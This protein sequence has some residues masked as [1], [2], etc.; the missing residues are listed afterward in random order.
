MAFSPSHGLTLGAAMHHRDQL[1]LLTRSQAEQALGTGWLHAAGHALAV[2]EPT[3]ALLRALL[4]LPGTGE[5][6]LCLTEAYE[7][8][9]CGELRRC[10]GEAPL[11]LDWS[12]ALPLVQLVQS[13]ERQARAALV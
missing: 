3:R 7:A 12:W 13:G 1:P 6:L 10:D 11:P 5:T 8:L 9:H 2:T 4:A